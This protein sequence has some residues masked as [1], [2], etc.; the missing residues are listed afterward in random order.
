VWLAKL[1]RHRYLSGSR[2]ICPDNQSERVHRLVLLFRRLTKYTVVVASTFLIACGGGPAHPGAPDTANGESNVVT[3]IERLLDSVRVARDL[4]AIGGAIV[5][6]TQ[7]TLGVV[8]VRRAGG[9]IRV[10]VNDKFHLG[11]MLKSMTSGLMALLVDQGKVEWTAT[12]ADAFPELASTMRPEYRSVTLLD[13]LSQQSG[14]PRDPTISFNDPTP[15]EQRAKLVAWAVQQPG[16]TPR[17]T[18]FYSNVYYMIAGAIAERVTNTA[19][20][21]LIVDQLLRPLGLTTV[22]FGAAGTPNV[23]DQPW[24]HRITA[25]GSRVAV[26]PSPSADNAP[27]YGP[28]GRAHMSVG[29]WARWIQAVLRAEAGGPSPWK[30]AT[31]GILTA[32]R[33]AVSATDGYALGWATTTRSWASPTRRVLTHD[34]TNLMNYAVAW[35]APDAG[36]AVIL[37]TNQG[38]ADAAAAL[39]VAASRLITL[40][41]TGR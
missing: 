23:E 17:G 18:Y 25:S 19:F 26:S 7:V 6:R 1:A 30:P 15:R 37:V 22:G 28:A 27:V 41:L 5:T 20:E 16:P 11:S 38:G 36:F 10:T 12:L 21:Q 39:D 34:G 35:L 32:P 13:L 14:L 33:V 29:D 31:A 40:H 8:G 9:T 2:G 24:Q 4:P 3:D